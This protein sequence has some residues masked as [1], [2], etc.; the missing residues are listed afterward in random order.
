M[1]ATGK[2]APRQ[3]PRISTR[4]V[5]RIEALLPF[6]QA[7]N[8][9]VDRSPTRTVFQTFEWLQSWWDAFGGWNQLSVP[10]VFA[11]DELI[12]AGPLFTCENRVYGGLRNCMEFGCGIAAD[13]QDFLYRDEAALRLLVALVKTELAWDV[14]ELDKI[15]EASPTAGV[16][17]QAF[18]GWTGTLFPCD[19][20]A[21]YRFSA[22]HDGSQI[23]GKRNLVSVQRKLRKRG[24][25]VVRH[26]CAAE[27]IEPYL[28]A[29]FDQHIKRRSVTGVQSEFVDPRRRYFYR[30]L[31]E[32]MA[33]QHWL[34]FSVIELNGEP[35]AFHFGF[36]YENTLTFYKTSF[37]IEH[38]KTSSPG[39]FLLTELFRYCQ[40]A[41]LAELDLTVGE[42]AYKERFANVTRRN[43]RFRAFR[44]SMIQ[45]LDRLNR[46]LRER[47]KKIPALRSLHAR[48]NDGQ[49][50]RPEETA[51]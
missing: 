16:M 23:L 26:L 32:R 34:L 47:A 45:R 7:W 13:Y 9:L 1:I 33:R 12:A 51:P 37:S 30:L 36:V 4:I 20:V 10:L 35:I 46:S 48:L 14:L 44:N 40:A 22:E 18:P 19:V 39:L 21:A 11:D 25:V 8:G 2:P 42:H 43:L 50:R 3:Q 17:V 41:G 24:V 29:F 6:R 31:T 49:S 5:T 15:P 28:G 38:G 27:E